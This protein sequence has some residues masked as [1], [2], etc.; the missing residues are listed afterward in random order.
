MQLSEVLLVT[1]GT[2]AGSTNANSTSTIN[3]ISSKSLHTSN[4]PTTGQIHVY[5]AR[6]SMPLGSFKN[7]VTPRHGLAVVP[8]PLAGG[9]LGGLMTSQQ[10][11][12]FLHLYRWSKVGDINFNSYLIYL[13]IYIYIYI[14]I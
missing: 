7:S 2:T 8:R 6:T 9:I 13:Y 10:D 5:E 1:T 3:G 4:Q 14:Y 12:A 11:R